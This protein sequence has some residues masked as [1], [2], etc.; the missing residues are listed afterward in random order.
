VVA[1][2]EPVVIVAR[3]RGEQL[4]AF[5][6]LP[7]AEGLVVGTPAVPIG[8]YT[9]QILDRAAPTE[10]ADFRAR[11]EA[12]IVS[13]E[14]DVRQVLAKVVLGEADAGVVYRTDATSVGDAVRVL[15]IPPAV[16]VVARYPA[17]IV[18]GTAN[19]AMA[20]A[21]IDVL[22]G[23]PGQAALRRAGFGAP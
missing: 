8:R 4:Q 3:A 22:T 10:G 16:N 23:A 13:R 21:W 7:R 5:G 9:L 17:A 12:R 18:K 11:V 15:P 1:T 2:N 14:L 6:D 19:R 20:R